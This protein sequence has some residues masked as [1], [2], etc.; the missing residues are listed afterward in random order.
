[1][2]IVHLTP[3]FYPAIGGIETY[4]NELSRR[5][6]ERG[7]KVSVVTSGKLRDGKQLKK[8]E[9][10]D[11][12]DVYRV[13]F[14]LVAR[15]N[16]STEAFKLL[17]DLDYD[18]LHIHSIGYF[19]DIIPVLKGMKNV[20]IVVSTHGGIFHT[21]HMK[22]LKNIYFKI[23]V[24]N[25]LKSADFII[26]TSVK[27]YKLFSK[28]CDRRKMGIIHPGVNWGK[29]SHLPLSRSKNRLLY[30]GR[31]AENKR[32]DRMLHVMAQLKLKVNDVKLL[33]IGED[34]GEKNKLLK[35]AKKM[36]I[37]DNVRFVSGV[38]YHYK[39]FSR[40]N[41]FLLSSEYEGFG[42]SVV[43]AMAAGLPVVVNDIET[44]HEI[45][46]NGKDGYIVNFG[47]YKKVSEFLYKLLINS[48]LQKKLG[49]NAK[50][51]AKKFDW[52]I[53]AGKIEKVYT[54]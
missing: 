47:D 7:Y 50:R 34:W 45:V 26:A 43:E 46:K 9:K 35:L 4:V 22:L 1:M 11:G 40:S 49:K 15:Y 39:Y 20:R 29:F 6:V 25:A 33:L 16:F 44:M 23:L 14:K 8:F 31:F 10:I 24:K 41:A 5:Q 18:V 52:D 27:D 53:I 32:L 13:P 19:T 28:I 30:V 42:T 36:D 54:R 2:R 21:P 12:I 17:S 48:G 37:L 51:S 38:K 3:N